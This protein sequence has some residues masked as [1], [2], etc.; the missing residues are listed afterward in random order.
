M[1]LLNAHGQE[2]NG[3]GGPWWAKDLRVV[4][5]MTVIAVGLVYLLAVEVRGD[6]KAAAATATAMRSELSLHHTHTE[7]L[8]ASIEGYMRVQLLLLRQ[9][10]NNAA[11]TPEERRACFQP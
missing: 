1:A 6:A 7:A 5:P 10:C 11:E 2:V 9:L 4:G 3:N 8:H